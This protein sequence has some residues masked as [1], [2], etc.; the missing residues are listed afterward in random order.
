M[1]TLPSSTGNVRSDLLLRN[2]KAVSLFGTEHPVLMPYERA[3]RT[4]AER[5]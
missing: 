5:W 3:Q 4:L 2:T 1:E